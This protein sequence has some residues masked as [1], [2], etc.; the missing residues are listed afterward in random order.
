MRY[1]SYQWTQ[2]RFKPYLQKMEEKNAI[3]VNMQCKYKQHHVRMCMVFNA[4]FINMLVIS[5]RS[6]LLVDETGVPGETYRPVANH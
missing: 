6:V 2:L 4:T 3:L 1:I 5:W